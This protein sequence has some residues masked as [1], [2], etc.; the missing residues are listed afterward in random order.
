MID[1]KDQNISDE[2]TS[3]I[4]AIREGKRE[5][6]EEFYVETKEEF[7]GWGQSF[8]SLPG[9][10]LIDIYQDAQLIFYERIVSGKLRELRSQP[11]TF[12]IGIAKNLILS[13]H[14]MSIREQDA[15]ASIAKEE[16]DPAPVDQG[17]ED[18]SRL[19]MKLLNE[20]AEPC[21]TILNLFY[22]NSQQLATIAEQLN[23]KNTDVVKSQK[24]RCL[25]SLKDKMKEAR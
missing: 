7:L 17:L 15:R 3:W 9:E 13:K 8:S 22:Y 18:L 6:M 16:F 24:S 11:K 21:K 20:M 4:T 23:Y 19:A 1:T 10:E 25:K 12:L 2:I 14:R 5:L